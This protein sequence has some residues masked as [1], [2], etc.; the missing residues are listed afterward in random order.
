MRRVV[1][2]L[3]AIATALT[4]GAPGA[5]AGIEPGLNRPPNVVTVTCTV[6]PGADTAATSAAPSSVN[7]SFR[8]MTCTGLSTGMTRVGLSLWTQDSTGHWTWTTTV[9]A[10][11]LT[12]NGTVTTA[13]K[14]LAYVKVS[15]S[16]YV[17]WVKIAK[18]WTNVARCS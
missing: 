17:N 13:C 14:H 3:F 18:N 8:G 10:G 11:T 7:I 5:W 2:V 12:A 9:G 16:Y 4:I 15:V 6:N 1:V